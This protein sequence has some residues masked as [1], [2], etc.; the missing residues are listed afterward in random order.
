MRRIG[1]QSFPC[2]SFEID[3]ERCDRA[4]SYRLNGLVERFGADAAL[5][6][7]LEALARCERKADF[8]RPCG[9]RFTDLA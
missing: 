3:C 1:S 8:R 7:V 6:D 5:P 4:G 9:A 2:P